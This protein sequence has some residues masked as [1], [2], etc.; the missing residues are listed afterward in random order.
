VSR[1]DY[2]QMAARYDGARKIEADGLLGWRAAIER[3]LPPRPQPRILDLGAGTGQFCFAL[4][5]WFDAHVVALE[6]SAG[7]RRQARVKSADPRVVL[8]GGNAERIPL[9]AG[10]CDVA[11]LST[12]IH[13]IPDLAACARELKRVLVEDGIVLIRSAFPGRLDE[14]TLFHFFPEA[15][16]VADTFPSVATTVAA[17]NAAGFVQHSLERVSQISAPSLREACERVRLRA[18]TTLKALSEAEFAAGL[19]KVERAA[20]EDQTGAPVIDRLDLLVFAAK[21]NA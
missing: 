16:R 13:H 3:H 12:V 14:I 9:R 5:E 4:A 20:R 6:P 10:I 18:D 2:D 8:L 15:R 7:M 11:W 21:C 1:V 19:A 17:F